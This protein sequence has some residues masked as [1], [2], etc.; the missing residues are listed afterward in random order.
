MQYRAMQ[1]AGRSPATA[2]MSP[3]GLAVTPMPVPVV[4]SQMSRQAQCLYV[5]NIPFGITE[6]AMMDFFNA[7]MHL[8]C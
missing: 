6:E 7:Q 5:G 4:G 1:A 2:T 3:D 8:G